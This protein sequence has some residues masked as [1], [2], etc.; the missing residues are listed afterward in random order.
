L[1]LCE[2]DAYSDLRTSLGLA[3]GYGAP[4]PPERP[5]VER[6]ITMTTWLV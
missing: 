6:P 5:L 1:W 2:V 4:S 3:N